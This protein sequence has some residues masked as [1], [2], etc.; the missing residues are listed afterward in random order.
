MVSLDVTV[1]D[2]R[3]G[4]V[5]GLAAQNFRVLED[6]VPQKIEFFSSEDVPVT[7]GLVIDGSGSMRAKRPHVIS[8]A[9]AFAMASNPQDEIFVI[10]FND[11]LVFSLQPGQEFTS[12]VRQLQDALVRIECHGRTALYDAVVAAL[13][14]LGKGKHDKK[15]LLIVSDGEDNAS[16]DE[17]PAVLEVARQSNATIYAIAVYDPDSERHNTKVLKKL[18][19]AT[20]GEF[21]FPKTVPEIGAVCRGI[22]KDIRNQYTIAYSSTNPARDG[23]F[24][25][26]VVTATGLDR[27][28]LTIRAREGYFAPGGS[29]G[30]R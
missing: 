3:G 9:L 22:A 19:K 23:L 24:R 5:S 25:K 30:R 7:V 16:G 6:G 12:D 15:A 8:A 2:R 17:F 26:V 28:K 21:F 18:T 4:F 11:E 13:E 29:R 14:H 1:L 20:G 27:Q 10:H